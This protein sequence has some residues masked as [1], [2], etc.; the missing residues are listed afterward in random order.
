[1]NPRFS[2]RIS[3]ELRCKP[4][5]QIK[6]VCRHAGNERPIAAASSWACGVDHGP[7]APEIGKCW[8]SSK[9]ACQ[10]S[11]V[12][13]SGQ[14][15]EAKSRNSTSAVARVL[16]CLLGPAC[17]VKRRT[18]MGK[19]PDKESRAG[20][21]RCGHRSPLEPSIRASRNLPKSLTKSMI[22]GYVLLQLFDWD[23]AREV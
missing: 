17:C 20:A 2:S 8:T 16:F 12:M 5:V 3:V 1:M 18:S 21:P 13:V 4:V 19:C 9:A 6:T 14:M 22:A 23:S 7:G 15:R 10:A 11:T